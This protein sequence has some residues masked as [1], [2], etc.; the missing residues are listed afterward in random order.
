M[1]S[2]RK[3]RAERQRDLANEA[4]DLVDRAIAEDDVAGDGGLLAYA[5]RR[6]HVI[7]SRRMEKLGANQ[8]AKLLCAT[9]GLPVEVIEF[10]RAG[11]SPT[12]I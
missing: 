6:T 7:M 8:S 10:I 12:R 5:Q 11:V 1:A 2:K 3:S 4:K 9:R